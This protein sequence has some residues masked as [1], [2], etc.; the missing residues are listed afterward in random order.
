[1]PL[2]GI[3]FQTE[4]F[5]DLLWIS[6]KLRAC[7]IRLLPTCHPPAPKLPSKIGMP[8]ETS[9]PAGV[10][11]R[12]STGSALM[13]ESAL[14]HDLHSSSGGAPRDIEMA[15][16]TGRKHGG[17]QVIGD[18]SLKSLKSLKSLQSLQSMQSLHGDEQVL[19]TLSCS[20]AAKLAGGSP[21]DEV[22]GP[23]H[24][25]ARNE[26]PPSVRKKAS[27]PPQRRKLGVLDAT[28]LIQKM[29]LTTA[30]AAGKKQSPALPSLKMPSGHEAGKDLTTASARTRA[31]GVMKKSAHARRQTEE[32][33]AHEAL[34]MKL[35]AE[36]TH[37]AT[38][39]AAQQARVEPHPNPLTIT[40][41]HHIAPH[42][43]PHL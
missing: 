10:G 29:W 31:S 6:R 14:A 24:S 33:V 39:L 15:S 42:P 43:H 13:Q 16:G 9:S 2:S 37:E 17:E 1:M 30:L 36:A 41:M 5:D 32:E 12:S 26:A 7:F 20:T 35:E 18:E 19:E 25:S 3:L 23:P 27:K 22:E 21:M 40:R 4:L 38:E 8:T 34:R 11:Y 28:L